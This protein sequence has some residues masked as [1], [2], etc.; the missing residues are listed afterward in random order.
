MNEG[1]AKLNISEWGRPE[2][3]GD[4]SAETVQNGSMP[5]WFYLLPHPEAQLSTAER[6]QLIAGLVATF[7]DK[8][9]E[10]GGERDS[11]D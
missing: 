3:E 1:R 11:G 8:R 4:E 10:R 9:D 6:E 7:G 5:P 2:N